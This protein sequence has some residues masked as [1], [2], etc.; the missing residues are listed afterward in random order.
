MSGSKR[1]FTLVELLV[2]IAIIGSLVALLL[3]AV[4]SAR[5]SARRAQSINNLKQLA[6]AMHGFHDAHGELPH[7]GNWTYGWW[8]FGFQ[9]PTKPHPR[10]AVGCSWVYKILPFMEQQGL[11]DNFQFDI[12]VSTLL[13]PGRAGTGLS[14]VPLEDPTVW[15]FIR[16][17]GAVTDYAANSMVIGNVMIQDGRCGITPSW[18]GPPRHWSSFD[19]QLSDI[20]D[21]TS[22]TIL[23]GTKALAT[24][25][26]D[27]RG[28]GDG[29]EFTLTNGTTRRTFDDP[30]SGAGHD[31]N[32]LVRGISPDTAEYLC[33]YPQ[34]GSVPWVDFVPG[35]KFGINRSW[36]STYKQS[37]EVVGDAI[38]LDAW[39]RWGSPYE[40][41]PI[42]MAD[43]SVRLIANGENYE[44]LGPL[45]TP[46][47]GD[48]TRGD[49]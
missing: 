20:T 21:G 7:N 45:L 28:G 22:K 40:A 18:T 10:M 6:L 31:V 3:P 5:N 48:Q 36:R 11:Y 4:Q 34:G 49:L 13:D 32:G 26:Y 1:G 27:M 39:N 14:S 33:G 30:I 35:Q 42:A 29:L 37:V 38:D 12:A 23:L 41:T 8:H 43:G 19:R 24:Q 46:Q 2:V 44:T 25:A 9:T 15:G 47:G 17:A 16:A